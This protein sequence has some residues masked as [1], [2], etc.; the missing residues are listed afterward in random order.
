MGSTTE[1]EDL[2]ML[3]LAMARAGREEPTLK[4]GNREVSCKQPPRPPRASAPS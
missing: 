3:R 1:P 2:E 4:T